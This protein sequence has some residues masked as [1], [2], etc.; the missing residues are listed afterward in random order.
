MLVLIKNK[1]SFES[2][3][4]YVVLHDMVT[5]CLQN[6]QKM[7]VDDVLTGCQS[8]LKSNLLDKYSFEEDGCQELKLLFDWFKL[9]LTLITD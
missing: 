6:N 9:V 5:H 3:S 7:F 4:L 2:E 8:Q 1:D